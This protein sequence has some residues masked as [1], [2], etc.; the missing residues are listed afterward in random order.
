MHVCDCVCVYCHALNSLKRKRVSIFQ[1]N[2]D[3]LV[4]YMHKDRFVGTRA[5]GRHVI[6]L[7]TIAP[8]THLQLKCLYPAHKCV[9]EHCECFNVFDWFDVLSTH[10][11]RLMTD[12][13]LFRQIHGMC[14]PI[15]AIRKRSYR[16]LV[17]NVYD[18]ANYRRNNPLSLYFHRLA[19]WM[20]FQSFCMQSPIT[21]HCDDEY[22]MKR[23]LNH[24][25]WKL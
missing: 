17:S 14:H 12:I 22:R 3:T 2:P 11:I 18:Y 25:T 13:H 19:R 5:L 10:L 6:P 7:G 1:L 8:S 16:S 24:S 23:T 4:V 20:A 9:R 21:K 15:N